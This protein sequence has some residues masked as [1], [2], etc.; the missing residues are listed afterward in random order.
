MFCRK[1]VVYE[2]SKPRSASSPS[3]LPAIGLKWYL[4]IQ[5]F[6][7]FSQFHDCKFWNRLH[8]VRSVHIRSFSDP[9]FPEFRMNMGKYEPENLRIQT[10]FTQCYFGNPRAMAAFE[11]IWLYVWWIHFKLKTNSVFLQKQLF[12]P[13]G[14]CWAYAHYQSHYQRK[15]RSSRSQIFFKISTF[16][17]FAKFTGKH[18]CQSLR[19]T[20]LLK[21][22]SGAGIFLWIL[23]N[24]KEHFFYT[25]PLVAAS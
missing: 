4:F 6:I 5:Q 18:L 2:Q 25:T 23:R 7:C 12:S 11:N 16:K 24:F 21:K 22:D 9:Y 13:R 19:P 14:S 1:K 10:L 3:F 17:E 15:N 8:C 20:T